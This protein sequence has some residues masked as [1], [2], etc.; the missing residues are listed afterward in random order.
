[1]SKR[2]KEKG[3]LE[4]QRLNINEPLFFIFKQK[5]F[6]HVLIR[7]WISNLLDKQALKAMTPDL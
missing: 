4:K 6:L 3:K 1:M 2:K 5:I 7:I